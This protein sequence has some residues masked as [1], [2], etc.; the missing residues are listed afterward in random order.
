IVIYAPEVSDFVVE[1]SAAP[2][3]FDEPLTPL[4]GIAQYQNKSSASDR[5]HVKGTVTYQRPGEDLFLQDDSGGLQVKS[6]QKISLAPGDVV[7]A[8]RFPGLQNFLPVLAAAA[9]KQISGPQPTLV[10]S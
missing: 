5:I 4:N 9:L 7:E 1:E 8:V 10:H 3:P 6:M 2:N